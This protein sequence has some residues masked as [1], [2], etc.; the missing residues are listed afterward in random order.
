MMDHKMVISWIKNLI[1]IFF[2]Y[3][4]FPVK[5]QCLLT[6]ILFN[7]RGSK[8][9]FIRPLIMP[10][11]P[12]GFI[13][14]VIQKCSFVIQNCRNRSNG[15][16]SDENNHCPLAE[17]NSCTGVLWLKKGRFKVVKQELK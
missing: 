12:L 16:F 14:N 2:V 6:E 1:S 5:G 10:F 9:W 17:I 13:S 11:L 8:L 15:P 4:R 3:I 7:Q